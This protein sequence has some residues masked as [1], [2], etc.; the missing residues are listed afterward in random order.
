MPYHSLSGDPQRAFREAVGAAQRADRLVT[1]FGS[2]DALRQA[3]QSAPW[4]LCST[5]S[6]VRRA[7]LCTWGVD[8]WLT[9]IGVGRL[10]YRTGL[11]RLFIRLAGGYGDRITAMT[12]M[13]LELAS[14]TRDIPTG[15]QAPARGADSSRVVGSSQAGR[16]TIEGQV[17][18]TPQQ[19]P[20]V[21]NRSMLPG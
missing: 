12:V 18:V 1:Y 6:D 9:R 21:S 8:S 14:Q 11:P 13:R 7:G 3:A 17:D 5:A 15:L 4:H 19:T 20:N 16:Q 10:A 2:R